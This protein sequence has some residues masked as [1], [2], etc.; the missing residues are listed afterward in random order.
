MSKQSPVI[1]DKS[2]VEFIRSEQ[3]KL[4]KKDEAD[5][6]MVFREKKS[7]KLEQYS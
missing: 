4:K 6:K 2:R 1:F 7:F 3:I 5:M